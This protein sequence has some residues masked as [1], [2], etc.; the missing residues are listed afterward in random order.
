MFWVWKKMVLFFLSIEI[1]LFA[2]VYFFGPNGWSMLTQLKKSNYRLELECQNLKT[3]L[4][5]LELDS[6]EWSES[7]FLKEKVAREQLLMK[8]SGEI[9]YFR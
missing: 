9:I 4:A 2:L 6:Q 1:I 3:K 8:K 5:Q 7:S